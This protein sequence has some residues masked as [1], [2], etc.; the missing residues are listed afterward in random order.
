MEQ[1]RRSPERLDISA[2][3]YLCWCFI[4][5]IC[6][7]VL[8]RMADYPPLVSRLWES[9]AAIA[10]VSAIIS[11]SLF[12]YASRWAHSR[13]LSLYLIVCSGWLMLGICV[14]SIESL[15]HPPAS[16]LSHA[17]SGIY[18]L[19]VLKIDKRKPDSARLEGE[20]QDEKTDLPFRTLSRV[21]VT[22]YHS[23]SEITE[24]DEVVIYG[25]LFP[26]SPPVFANSPD[27]SRQLRL[28]D[29]AATGIGYK[30]ISHHSHPPRTFLSQLSHYRHGLAK[31][32]LAHMSPDQGAI[33]S[34]MLLGVRD[35][36]QNALYE[37][38]RAAGLA[39]LL[40][41]LFYL[42]LTGFP[43]SAIR[44]FLISS[45]VIIA[46]ISDRLALTYRNLA[47]VG[48][49]ILLFYPSAVYTASFQLSFSATFALVTAVQIS[50]GYI[51]RIP[52]VRSFLF[53]SFSS[54]LIT[55]FSLPFA[56]W[57]FATISLWGVA[58]NIVAIP[59]TGMVIMPAGVLM[60]VSL[61][62]GLPAFGASIM[63]LSLS[64]LLVIVRF[65]AG[66]PGPFIYL[67]P[68]EQLYL[69]GWTNCI[70]AILSLRQVWC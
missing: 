37:L 44:A 11:A 25:R 6:G 19:T 43:V 4:A 67:N 16:A 32:I 7:I 45:L 50:G 66:L 5:L 68:P 38:F 56:S 65:F 14:A 41:S 23:G 13:L 17:Q 22:V 20:I 47:L 62:A 27:F 26:L 63:D 42:F 30:L 1:M 34:A 9:F 57:H 69:L 15:L 2:Q 10:V 40:A 60:L 54:A 8:T 51:G 28:R 52:F 53:L 3:F 33:A 64:L 70:L 46:I 58:S 21:R 59:L 49:I 36:V 61:I 48:I 12:W 31:Q 35:Y 24:G 55:L 18:T 29:I 39:H